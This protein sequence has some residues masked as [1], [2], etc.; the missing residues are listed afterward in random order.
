MAIRIKYFITG[1]LFGALFPLGAFI[2]ELHKLSLPFSPE[3]LRTIHAN[4]PILYMID[5]APLFLG[6]FALLGGISKDRSVQLIKRFE[7]MCSLLYDKTEHVET[8]TNNIFTHLDDTIGKLK[9]DYSILQRIYLKSNNEIFTATETA[10]EIGTEITDFK[11]TLETLFRNYTTVDQ[12]NEAIKNYLEKYLN[13]FTDLVAHIDFLDEFSRQIEILAINSSIEA[14]HLGK[15][16]KSFLVFADTIHRLVQ[17]T[18]VRNSD[19][20]KMIERLTGETQHL[21]DILTGEGEK[22]TNMASL[23]KQINQM[24]TH[25][26]SLNLQF[27]EHLESINQQLKQQDNYSSDFD[28]SI[29]EM[30]SASQEMFSQLQN[31]IGSQTNIIHQLNKLR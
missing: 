21:S 31:L 30:T 29:V 23:N 3:N 19:I 26:N 24:T 14:N 25:F 16:A 12:Q 10:R 2:F 11:T 22:I 5:S 13:G 18:K 6:L 20:L 9:T 1:A 28:R 17:E 7:S 15:E 27:I 8:D 4:N